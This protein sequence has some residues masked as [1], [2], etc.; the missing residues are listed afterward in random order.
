MS[1]EEFNKLQ[2]A[3]FM[4]A[5]QLAKHLGIGLST[6]WALVKNERIKS[7]KLSSR[8]TV[9]NVA[10]VEKALFGEVA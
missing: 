4:R 6:V 8:T 10:E 1:T 5:K 7:I 3:K 9:F 2:V